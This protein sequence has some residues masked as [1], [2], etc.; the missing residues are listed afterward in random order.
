MLNCCLI[1][2]L[3]NTLGGIEELEKRTATL[4]T[5]CLAQMALATDDTLWKSLN[6]EILL[7]TKSILPQVRIGALETVV[8]IA[9]KLGDDYLMLLPETIGSLAELLEDEDEKVET[10]MKNAIQK[11]EDA[12]GQPVREYFQ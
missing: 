1:H 3:E 10:A 12:L 4:L 8:A 11:M 9:V 5:P 2:Q 7:K 6:Y